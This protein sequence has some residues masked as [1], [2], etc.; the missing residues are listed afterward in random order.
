M[1]MNRVIHQ[2]NIQ[3]VLHHERLFFRKVTTL[4][5]STDCWLNF[6]HLEDLMMITSYHGV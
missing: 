4:H 1:F 3:T 5:Q 6:V 2:P